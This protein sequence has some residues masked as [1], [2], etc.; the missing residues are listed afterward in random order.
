MKSELESARHLTRRLVA[1]ASTQGEAPDVAAVAPQ[2]ACERAYRHLA[3]SFGVAGSQALLARALTQ[4]QARQPV[5]R[6]LRLGRQQSEP[7]LLG[8]PEMI[9]SHGAPKVAAALE[10][11][12]EELLGVLGRLLGDDMVTR[13]VEQTSTADKNDDE[14]VI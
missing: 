14:D 12:L 2:A 9:L 10:T 8:V 6:D 3:R 1:R 4:A 7:A 13:L 5:L 11:V